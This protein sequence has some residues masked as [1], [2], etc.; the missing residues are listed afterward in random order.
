M[1]SVLYFTWFKIIPKKL[2]SCSLLHLCKKKAIC[3]CGPSVCHRN[4]LRDMRGQE[5]DYVIVVTPGSPYFLAAL[6]FM[7]NQ[8][9]QMTSFDQG[10]RA[11]SEEIGK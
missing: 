3:H 1:I 8:A 10:C 2:L 5:N 11:R 9:V 7:P 4:C 6:E